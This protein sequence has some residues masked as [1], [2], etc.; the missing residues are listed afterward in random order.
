MNSSSQLMPFIY[1]AYSYTPI[2]SI[3]FYEDYVFA[4]VCNS[5]MVIRSKNRFAW[6]KFYETSDTS[7]TA[8]R[9]INGY[10]YTGTSPEGNI[11][12]T[13]LSQNATKKYGSFGSKIV[14]FEAFQGTVYVAINGI[15][16]IYK[17]KYNIDN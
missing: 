2:S 15:P 9:I 8:I 7:V 17:Y 16:R 5:G 12:I 3:D 10:L 11:Y 13:N 4:G 14:G 1:E 6:E